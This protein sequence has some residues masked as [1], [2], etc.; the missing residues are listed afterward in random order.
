MLRVKIE[1]FLINISNFEKGT[2][3]KKSFL[4]VENFRD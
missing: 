2:R 3:N 4:M 1:N